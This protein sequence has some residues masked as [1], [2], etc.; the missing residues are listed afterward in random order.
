[1]G[2]K[3]PVEIYREAQF[4]EEAGDLERAMHLYSESQWHFKAVNIAL[5]LGRIDDALRFY[6]HIQGDLL[7]NRGNEPFQGMEDSIYLGL[8]NS[9]GRNI[10]FNGLYGDVLDVGCK[11]GRF[12]RLL[13]R[14]GAET[15]YGVDLDSQALI[16]ARQKSNISQANVYDCKVEELPDKFN[17]FFDYATIFNFSLGDTED[18]ERAVDDVVRI[19]KPSGRILATF[20]TLDELR[21]YS[22]EISRYFSTRQSSLINGSGEL[23]SAPHRYVTHGVRK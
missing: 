1:M 9:A 3:L 16:E 18:R 6:R 12:F 7:P 11:D 20:T 13:K 23:D 14:L 5:A 8:I 21:N 4:A 2:Q 22:P 19:L 15:V 17:G 10:G